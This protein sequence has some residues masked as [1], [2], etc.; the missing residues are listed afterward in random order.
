[1][2]GQSYPCGK[3]AGS[4]RK[5]LF[6]EHLGLI[7][8]D[9]AALDIDISDPVCDKFFKNTWQY[10]SKRNTEMYED[11]FNCI[12]TDAVHSF[13]ELKRYQEEHPETLWHKDRV[14]ANRKI[15]LIQGYIV[16]FPLEFLCNETLTPKN[17][18]ME[19][20]MPT[21]LWT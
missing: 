5:Q 6:R 14:L 17:I 21:S 11:V 12:P 2:N 13:N 8:K 19:G 3:V 9:P 1:M 10:I 4:L 20:M 15:D 18:S 16:D 7:D